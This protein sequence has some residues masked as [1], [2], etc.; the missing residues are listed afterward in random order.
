DYVAAPGGHVHDALLGI[1]DARRIHRILHREPRLAV[2]HEGFL[3]LQIMAATDRL[4][5]LM[6]LPL[7]SSCYG[8]E[9][10]RREFNRWCLRPAALWTRR[11]RLR[12][13]QTG[14]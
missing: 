10:S 2:V 9:P 13:G 12:S 11:S 4:S 3:A 8:R 6:S 5:H 7:V 14:S 1:F